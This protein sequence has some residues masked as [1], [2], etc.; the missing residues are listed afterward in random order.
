MKLIRSIKR[1]LREDSTEM[2]ITPEMKQWFEERTRNHIQLVQKWAQKIYDY[3]Q[4][5]FS[6]LIT[7]VR[8]HDQSKYLPPEVEPYV[9]IS[10]D[11]HCK[12]KGIDFEIP[13][14]IKD[15]MNQASNHHVKSNAHHPE[16]WSTDE[17]G[18]ELVNR[19]DRDKLLNKCLDAIIMPEWAIAEMCADWFAM[20]EEL[21][22]S[23]FD[24]AKKNINIRWKFT[25]EQI[26]LISELLRNV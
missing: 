9:Y 18:G 3:D 12:D 13:Q 22:N 21:N 11:Y 20:S 15:A 14:D 5:R 6:K 4:Q 1:F 23:P 26:I 16:Y 25:P 7:S 19:E 8:T 17:S 2:A 10:W 24:W